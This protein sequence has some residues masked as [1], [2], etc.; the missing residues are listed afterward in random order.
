MK[1]RKQFCEI[2]TGH[3]VL[4]EDMFPV[5]NWKSW[6]SRAPARHST[7]KTGRAP[8]GR[9]RIQ[10]GNNSLGLEVGPEPRQHRETDSTAWKTKPRLLP[11]KGERKRL[12][13]LGP[14]AFA[15]TSCITCVA[16]SLGSV[17]VHL[18]PSFI[19]GNAADAVASYALCSFPLIGPG[20]SHPAFC[21]HR[22]GS[23]RSCLTSAGWG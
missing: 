17:V 3:W 18:S 2:Y 8:C 6:W 11:P 21:G 1:R 13:P 23:Q 19:L 14:A 22:G 12:I 16:Y 10:K 15:A 7:P 20:L 5:T 9:P 4:R